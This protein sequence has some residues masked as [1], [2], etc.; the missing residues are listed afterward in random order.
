LKR[1]DPSII[2]LPEGNMKLDVYAELLLEAQRTAWFCNSEIRLLEKDKSNGLKRQ[3]IEDL[4]VKKTTR[5][6]AKATMV[7]LTQQ[8]KKGLY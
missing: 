1:N 6:I 3:K 5:D 2:L 4:F 8:I 7:H